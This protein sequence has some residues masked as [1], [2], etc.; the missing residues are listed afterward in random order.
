ME[1]TSWLIYLNVYIICKLFVGL[2]DSL[3]LGILLNFPVIFLIRIIN[4][5]S[6][7]SVILILWNRI[8]SCT[9]EQHN[10]Y[11]LVLVFWEITIYDNTTHLIRYIH[12]FQNFAAC[13]GL[14][15]YLIFKSSST[16][17]GKAIYNY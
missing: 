2:L 1:A 8:S 16:H 14:K 9:E 4:L 11:T 13:I 3:F 5:T 7:D 12:Q 6:M 17:H 10:G 15:Q